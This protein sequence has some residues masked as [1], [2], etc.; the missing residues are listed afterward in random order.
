MA[1]RSLKVLITGDSKPLDKEA[2]K[3][4]R[5]LADLGKNGSANLGKLD[6]AL[7]GN[8]KRLA[9]MA[10][11]IVSVG[12]A[13]KTLKSSINDVK[14]LTTGTAQLAR[15]TGMDTKEASRWAAQAK[16]RGIETG[17]LN[18]AFVKLAQGIGAATQG[19][20][21]QGDQAK[22]LAVQQDELN[23]KL[24]EARKAGDPKAIAALEAQQAKLAIT[25]AA[26]AKGGGAQ[27]QA[28][29][30]LGVSS[31]ALKSGNTGAVLEEIA[32]GFA[33][34]ADGPEKA[35][36]AQKLF[37]KQSQTLLPLL[38]GGSKALRENLGLADKYGATIDDKTKKAVFKAAAA[39]RELNFAWLGVKT[40][41]GTALIPWVSKAMGAFAGL[42]A[43]MRSGTKA[44]DLIRGALDAVG[45]AVESAVDSVKQLVDGFRAGETGAT[46]IVGAL[47]GLAVTVVVAKGVRILAGAF[48][49]LKVSLLTNPIV[50][51]GVA[52]AAIGAGLLLAYRKSETFRNGVNQVW[53]SVRK[54]A[55]PILEQV[56]DAVI[57]AFETV[58][59]WLSRNRATIIATATTIFNGVADVARTLVSAFQAAVGFINQHR[60][61]ILNVA[62]VIVGGLSAAFNA[63][64]SSVVSAFE[65]IKGAI[66]AAVK[67][68][69]GWLAKH[70]DDISAFGRAWKNIATGVAVAVGAIAV[71]VREVFEHVI[72]PVVKRV[73][74]VV[75]DIVRTVWPSI[76]RIISGALDAIGG[77][78][79]VFS[80]IFTGDFD[81]I[82]DGVKGIFRGGVKSISGIL[83]AFIKGAGKIA[84]AIGDA[85]KDAIVGALKG[86][87]HALK[88]AI[89]AGVK[90]AAEK[91][92]GLIT[93]M[94][95]KVGK[96]IIGALVP[97]GDGIGRAI[98]DG[99]GAVSS[100]PAFGG[101]LM[102]AK[103]SMAPFAGAAARFGLGVSSGLRPGAITSS[104]NPSYH[105]SGNAIDV[106]GPAASMLA[107]FR[108]MKARFGRVLRELIYTPGGVGIKDGRPYRYTGQVAADHFDHVH[109]A[110]TGAGDGIGR[111]ARTGDGIGDIRALWTRAGGDPAKQ[112]LAAA[113]AMAESGGRPNI[114]NRNSDGSIDRGLWQI[115]SVHGALSTLDR[116]GNAKAAISISSNGRN[117]NPWVAFKN[118]SYKQFLAGGGGGRKGSA[119]APVS[120]SRLDYLNADL[121]NAET[122]TT[123][124][125]DRRAAVALESYWKNRLDQAR[126]SGKPGRIADVAGEYKSA[127]ETAANINKQIAD[128]RPSL[129]DS[130]FEGTIRQIGLERAES[131]GDPKKTA[132][133]IYKEAVAKRQRLN[134]IKRALKRKLRKETRARLVEEA[135]QLTGDLRALSALM[136]EVTGGQGGMNEDGVLGG[137]PE[138]AA[139]AAGG[140]SGGG[141]FGGGSA[142]GAPSTWDYLDAE[143]SMAALTDG[144][145][146]DKYVADRRVWY[147]QQ[148]YNS[149]LA[150]GDPRVIR[151][152]AQRLKAE[153]DAMNSLTQAIKDHERTLTQALDE[154]REE[155][156]RSREFAQAVGATS[157]YQLT[158]TLADLISGHIVG[159]GVAGRRFTPGSGVEVADE[160]ADEEAFVLDG[161][162][163]NDSTFGLVSAQLPVP[164]QRQEWI[165]AADSEAQKLV[166]APLCENR[167][168]TLKLDVAQ[169]ASMDL[170][171]DKILAVLDKLQKAGKYTDGIGL[172]WTPAT[173]TR[174][175]TFDVLAGEI[176]DLP[177]DWE[178]GWLALAPSFT[179]ELTCAPYWRGQEQ[180]TGTVAGSAVFVSMEAP[181][182]TGDVPAL[183]R[184]IITDTAGQLRRHVE[185]GLEGP[186]TYNPATSLLLDSDN[187]VTS[188]FAGA[189]TTVSVGAYDPKLQ[190]PGCHHGQYRFKHHGVVWDREPGAR[191][192]VP[193]QVPDVH[194]NDAD[195]ISVLMAYR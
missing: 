54:N 174:S 112:N 69:S 15:S 172:T 129:S 121:A 169:Q 130:S 107:F 3:A 135:T 125:D 159:Y 95:G 116:L 182:V 61:T 76:K 92:P 193:A 56:K 66:S 162:A 40:V 189:Q 181:N 57:G 144:I 46:A 160:M 188:G 32:D 21:K 79:Q 137:T 111:V 151:D 72:A 6:T 87:G 123:L 143:Q 80:G 136:F 19:Q 180:L 132:A 37:G 190:W 73:M 105:G 192:N 33:K 98:G 2:K 11:G 63:A 22:K 158:K 187:L 44:G 26:V 154:H 195:A 52:I 179:I 152:A 109:I 14:S 175:V 176:V 141:D 102:G 31:K 23:R 133:L 110:Y 82:W 38:N 124:Q 177:I 48:E 150:S 153:T 12:A 164:R 185:W 142:S 18:T 171:H 65:A 1:T 43:H 58:V 30:D 45:R 4:D 81:R 70:R 100:L 178:S 119:K 163:L 84:I 127:R 184:L 62:R 173:G 114:T 88:D 16:V 89:V 170:A 39:Q 34:M 149:A 155:M 74:G 140:G 59:D 42:V 183:G 128:R 139:L 5:S 85:I 25:Q 51:V 55:I 13:T 27:A 86:I 90:W 7:G 126:K 10:A 101:G 99:V 168:I 64:R 20:A 24:A 35:A 49:L 41:I 147:A 117:W 161:L 156:R 77:I 29:R 131:E 134:A 157:E 97:G 68:V 108:Q 28:F 50:A 8:V 53:E 67:F 145:D 167:K 71:V 60:A 94:L 47:G 120:P 104:G 17:K 113:V 191:R 96:S 93:G 9:G 75:L 146:D 115:N 83:E 186:L 36:M 138:A 103:P 194:G 106:A 148:D 91:V 122:T 165:G 166:R 118:G 78:I